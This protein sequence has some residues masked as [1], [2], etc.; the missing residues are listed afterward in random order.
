[1][2][3]LPVLR[4]LD[5]VYER[6][7]ISRERERLKQHKG[8]RPQF[9]R[10]HAQWEKNEGAL[11]L[12]MKRWALVVATRLEKTPIVADVIVKTSNL[13]YSA[14]LPLSSVRN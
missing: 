1:M 6:V 7:K 11:S 13:T 2:V 4:A 9:A 5:R 10:K 12:R 8:L 14:Y 3:E